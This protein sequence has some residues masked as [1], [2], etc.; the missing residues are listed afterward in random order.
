MACVFF[1]IAIVP[2]AHAQDF[3]PTW[4]ILPFKN[5]TQLIADGSYAKAIDALAAQAAAI[6]SRMTAVGIDWS[7]VTRDD[8]RVADWFIGLINL[9]LANHLLCYATG[10]RMADNEVIATCVENWQRDVRGYWCPAKAQLGNRK[11]DFD[12]CL[13]SRSVDSD[14][15]AP[16]FVR[17]AEAIVNEAEGEL[18]RAIHAYEDGA[19]LARVISGDEGYLVD[20]KDDTVSA[21]MML[22]DYVQYRKRRGDVPPNVEKCEIGLV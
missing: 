19:P 16:Y 4:Q 3:D 22:D 21:A 5:E 11:L 17:L 14:S 2:V 10:R 1:V 15:W 9:N 20:L 8:P 13:N 7:N 18:E 6:D 12:D